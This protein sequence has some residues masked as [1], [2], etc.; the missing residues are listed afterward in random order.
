MIRQQIQLGA[1]KG[2]KSIRPIHQVLL[3]PILFAPSF[4]GLC[5][6][7]WWHPVKDEAEARQ[8]F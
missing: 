1:A 3:W 2:I 8:S 4:V 6:L 7:L 5:T